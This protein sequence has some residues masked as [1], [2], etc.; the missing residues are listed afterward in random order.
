[1]YITGPVDSDYM[2]EE[3]Q[4]S[5]ENSYIVGTE[6]DN[7]F[8]S[9]IVSNNMPVK[10]SFRINKIDEIDNELL[11]GATFELLDSNKK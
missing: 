7:D 3:S 1:M 11:N 4:N 9:I 8:E 6:D 2:K 10:Y 5:D